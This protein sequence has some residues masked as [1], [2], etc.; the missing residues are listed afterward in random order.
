MA[1]TFAAPRLATVAELANAMDNI[2]LLLAGGPLRFV[3]LL[4]ATLHSA[5]TLASALSLM[6]QLGTVRRG[7]GAWG[8]EAC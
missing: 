8:L 7:D 2:R 1:A 3:D 6:A 4:D 5:R